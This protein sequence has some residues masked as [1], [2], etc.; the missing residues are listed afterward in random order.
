[1]NIIQTHQYDDG[2]LI[3]WDTDSGQ[4]VPLDREMYEGSFIGNV[5]RGALRGAQEIE[6]GINEL[7]PNADPALV[8][9]QGEALAARQ[10]E[11]AAAA[12]WAEAIGEAVPDISAG[13]A[14]APLT[15]GM[16]L[17]GMVGTE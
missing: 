14:A 6:Q 2:Q 8:Q 17:P 3:G 5:G 7:L 16:S 11:A 15:G 12:P 9:A 13:L 1:M 10:Q 4:W